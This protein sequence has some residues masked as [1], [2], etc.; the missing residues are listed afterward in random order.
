MAHEH[1]LIYALYTDARKN[2]SRYVNCTLQTLLVHFA[3]TSL[4]KLTLTALLYNASWS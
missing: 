4:T 3:A 1:D 2:E